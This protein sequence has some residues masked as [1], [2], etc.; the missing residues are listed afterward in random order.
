MFI[1]NLLYKR[2]A[3]APVSLVSAAINSAGTALVLTFS[4]PVTLTPGTEANIFLAGNYRNLTG[5]SVSIAGSVATVTMGASPIYSDETFTLDIPSGVFLDSSGNYNP[6]IIG[7]PVTNNS[8]VG[9]LPNAV[10]NV[11]IANAILG[12]RAW[13]SRTGTGTKVTADGDSIGYFVDDQGVAWV[14]PSDSARAIAADM[15]GGKWA[16]WFDGVDDGYTQ[17]A[18]TLTGDSVLVYTATQEPPSG[19]TRVVQSAS[20]NALISGRRTLNTVYVG[21]AVLNTAPVTDNAPH[22]LMI[23]RAS[24][25]AWGVRLDASD[26]D[27]AQAAV[28]NDF[29]TPVLGTGSPANPPYFET[30]EGL[31]YGFAALAFNADATARGRIAAYMGSLS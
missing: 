24:A 5:S 10:L 12:G 16:A 8:T 3:K 15:G 4:R 6:E 30:F 18:A 1:T 20:V 11:N 26:T 7:F 31:M 14:A 21:G 17:S 28:S 25:T 27:L 13:I 9:Y 22:V 23:Y 29:G 2:S 19:V